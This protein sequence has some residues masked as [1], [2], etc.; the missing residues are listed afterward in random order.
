M[1][2]LV[3]HET[4][5]IG[6]GTTLGYNVIIEEEVEIGKWCQIGNGVIIHAKTKIGDNVRVDDCSTLGKKPLKAVMSIFKSE[7]AEGGA[8]IGDNTLIGAHSIVF[9]GAIIGK[10]VLIADHASIR[11]NSSIGDYTIIGRNVTVENKCHIGR[12]CKIETDVYIASISS[13]ED[14]CF[15]GPGVIFTNDNYLGRTEERFK[16]MKGAI[17]RKGARVGAGSIL[18]PGIELGEDCFIAAG[19]IVT[20]DAPARMLL[21]GRPAKPIREVDP[22][23]LLENNLHQYKE[24]K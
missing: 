12:F 6:S 2:N 16:H 23:Q 7:D 17:L 22:A 11:N 1:S 21:M 20:R 3:I 14:Y 15:V 19:S 13:I 8:I 4:A 10:N 18:L 9:A 5:R 24:I